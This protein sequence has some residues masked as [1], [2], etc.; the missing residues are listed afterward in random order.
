VDSGFSLF[1][2]LVFF[3]LSYFDCSDLQLFAIFM[4]REIGWSTVCANGKQNEAK[5]PLE[6][7][8]YHLHGSILV[9]FLVKD[10][11]LLCVV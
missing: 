3:R 6:I 8:L 2:G 4:A 7:G 1:K 9:V 11:S 5:P 10:P